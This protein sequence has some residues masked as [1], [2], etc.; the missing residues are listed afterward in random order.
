MFSNSTDHPAL[1]AAAAAVYVV[2]DDYFKKVL[3]TRAPAVAAI[4]DPRI[5]LYYFKKAFDNNGRIMN[6]YYKRLSAHFSKVFDA[7]A[8]R[9][10][11]I[12]LYNQL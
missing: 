9:E 5:K 2:I 8:A 7:Y 10:T 3:T 6:P 1:K 12:R 11:Q 4:I